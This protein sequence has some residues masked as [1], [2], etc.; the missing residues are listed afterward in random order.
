MDTVTTRQP[1]PAKPGVWAGPGVTDTDVPV[2]TDDDRVTSLVLASGSSFELTC[3]ALAIAAAIAGLAGVAPQHL[4]ALA[5]IAVGFALLAQGSTIAARWREAVHIPGSERTE[6]VGISTEMFGGLGAIVLGALVM[7]NVAPLAL[8]CAA[9]I[10]IGVSL[11]LGG[12]AQPDIAEAAPA[13]SPRR[14]RVTRNAVRTSAG[15]MV[16]AGLAAIALG[17]LGATG[18]GPAIALSLVAILC[19]AAALVLA[20]GALA[21]R[22]ARLT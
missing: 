19:T 14:W 22:F 7:A 10:V 13:A 17:V 20:G 12:P 16:M 8:S 15:V 5:T 21:A 3:G 18:A 2:V 9:A 6:A 4:A 11:L 1:P